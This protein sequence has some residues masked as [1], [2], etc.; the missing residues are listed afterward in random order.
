MF[1]ERLRFMPVVRLIAGIIVLFLVS[2]CVTEPAPGTGGMKFSEAAVI[3]VQDPNMLIPG[4]SSFAWL[5]EAINYYE[6]KRLADAPVRPLIEQTILDNIQKQGMVVLTSVDQAQY[7]I[8]YTA[9]LESSLDDYAIIRK[10]GLLPG[11]SRI[12]QDDDS[13]EKGSLI[14]YVFDNKAKDVIWRSAAQVGVK[15]DTP[16]EERRERVKR[17][18]AEMFLTFPVKE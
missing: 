5:P 7:A 1:Y 16:M 15:F 8:A 9:A 12:P 10:F 17:I 2:A 3:S 11:N 18:I 14:I 4:G 13:V 6:D